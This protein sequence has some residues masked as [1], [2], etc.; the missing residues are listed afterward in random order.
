MFPAWGDR[1]L[2]AS[3]PACVLTSLLCPSSP[4][5]SGAPSH[6]LPPISISFY[7]SAPVPL[8]QYLSPKAGPLVLQISGFKGW[9]LNQQH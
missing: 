9:A 2:P 8:P 5:S 6:H 1:H 7:L 4:S 3:S